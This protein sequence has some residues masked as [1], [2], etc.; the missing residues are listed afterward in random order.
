[1]LYRKRRED[2]SLCMKGPFFDFGPKVLRC[3]KKER[4]FSPSAQKAGS[5]GFVHSKASNSGIKVKQHYKVSTNIYKKVF[6]FNDN[7]LLNKYGF[8]Q[9]SSN[10]VS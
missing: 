8:L 5:I 6:T 9:R 3:E 2:A 1:M 7:F 4:C 10:N